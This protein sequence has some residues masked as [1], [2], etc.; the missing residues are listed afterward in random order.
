M[1][2]KTLK[3]FFVL[4]RALRPVFVTVREP[5]LQAEYKTK[6]KTI[7]GKNGERSS[8]YFH[9][10]G[11]ASAGRVASAPGASSA[12]S[13][14]LSPLP[15][16]SLIRIRDLRSSRIYVLGL[17]DPGFRIQDLGSK[18]QD[19]GSRTQ[20]LGQADYD[21]KSHA[22][23]FHVG[24]IISIPMERFCTWELEFQFPCNVFA[25]GNYN[26]NSHAVFLYMEIRISE[27][28]QR[29]RMWGCEFQ[30]PCSVF[31]FGN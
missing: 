2:P 30:F 3:Q 13:C 27:S 29:F 24:I 16:S 9:F 23:S 15:E 12:Y 4:R 14:F 19:P 6:P 17:R 18:I 28:M 11:A 21:C 20:L 31:A 1:K 8:L 25:C 26:F 5:F 22:A 7:K 10:F